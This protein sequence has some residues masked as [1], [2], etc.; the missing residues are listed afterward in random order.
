[1]LSEL[2]MHGQTSNDTISFDVKLQEGCNCK[3]GTS[4]VPIFLLFRP[5]N[6][7]PT[8]PAA[9]LPSSVF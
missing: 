5:M 6:R 4:Q 7:T 3:S 1:M 2:H 8:G 9:I